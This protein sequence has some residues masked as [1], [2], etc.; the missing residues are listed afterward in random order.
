M[1]SFNNAIVQPLP[2]PCE[3]R[4]V[5]VAIEPCG[6][7]DEV[8]LRYATWTDGLGWCNQKTIRLGNEQLDDLHRA[9]T[10]ARHRVNRKR[11]ADGEVLETRKVIQFP[12]LG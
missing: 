2:P 7:A 6:D 8:V 3:E 9:L 4:R 12:T 11:A 1:F 5:E 10:V